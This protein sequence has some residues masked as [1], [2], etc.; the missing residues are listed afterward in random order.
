MK[1]KLRA[2]T[3]GS[4]LAR[5]QTASV[6][7]RIQKKYPELEIE[8]VI[9]STKGDQDKSPLSE[10]AKKGEVGL[11]TKALEKTLLNGEIDFAVHSLKDL[12]VELPPGL[13]LGAVP[14]RVTPFDALVTRDGSLL[15][16]LPAGSRL[17]TSSLR[18]ASQIRY[19]FPDLKVVDLRG[20]LDTRVRKVEQGEVDAVILAAAGLLR[21]GYDKNIFTLLD[22]AICL[23]APGQGALAVEIRA[24]DA[25]MQ[26]IC[27]TVLD[28][29]QVHQEV[30]AER[31]L[32][33]AL[34]GGC[35]LPLGAYARLHGE[36][37]MLQGAIAASDGS[38]ILR[39][40]IT[41]RA[42]QPLA[43]GVALAEILIEK[44]AKEILACE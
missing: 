1:S 22:P 35:Q 24:G 8:E 28:D 42:D 43:V 31:A 38:R 40:E 3:R 18:R 27:A 34:G 19:H 29:Y 36:S 4:K 9:I 10:L 41:G 21:L 25:Q 23:P 44:G 26:E 5:W 15:E 12:T 14:E 16:D 6:I 30:V 7:A 17:G 37:L 13:S 11:F 32:L 20:N 33:Q 2:G 39:A